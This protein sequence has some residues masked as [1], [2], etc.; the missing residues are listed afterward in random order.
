MF[1]KPTFLRFFLGVFLVFY[2]TT[3]ADPDEVAKYQPKVEKAIAGM[4]RLDAKELEHIARSEVR[5][6]IQSV[7]YTTALIGDIGASP[8]LTEDEKAKLIAPL[9]EEAGKLFIRLTEPYHDPLDFPSDMAEL[10]REGYKNGFLRVAKWSWDH[11]IWVTH[12]AFKDLIRAFWPRYDGKWTFP[13][14]WSDARRSRAAKAISQDITQALEEE[15]NIKTGHTPPSPNKLRLGY[16]Y[17]GLKRI[18]RK[19]GEKTRILKPNVLDALDEEIASLHGRIGNEQSIAG[20]NHILESIRRSE[21][22]QNQNAN[23]KTRY[24][25]MAYGLLFCGL[26]FAPSEDPFNLFLDPN[27]GVGL[28]TFFYQWIT[29]EGFIN[30]WYSAFER[31]EFSPL[32]SGMSQLVF[33]GYLARVRRLDSGLDV[34]WTVNASDNRIEKAGQTEILQKCAKALGESQPEAPSTRRVGGRRPRPAGT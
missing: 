6:T 15:L 30:A 11:G 8:N 7:H 13:L 32:M 31:T 3:I 24:A 21:P 34:A 23:S 12:M 9:A 20:L 33:Y 18:L 27:P 29:G 17:G 26:L 4:K 5:P 1:L 2:S 22:Y 10:R 28:L 19:V 14:L 25:I 16:I